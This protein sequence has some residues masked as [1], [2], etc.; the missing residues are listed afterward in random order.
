M[1]DLEKAIVLHDYLAVNCEYDYENY[2]AN[3]IP[4]A[5]YTAYGV[6]VNRTAVCQGYA[7]A[8]KYLL[9]QTG[10]D[11]YMVSSEQWIMLGI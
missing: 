7:L 10:I 3:K 9:N 2:L 5:S 8:Y 6:L 1:S 4:D 11:C